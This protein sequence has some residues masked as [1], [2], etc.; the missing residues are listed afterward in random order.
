MNGKNLKPITIKSPANAP[1]LKIDRGQIRLNKVCFAYNK[2]YVLKNIN[3]E[4]KSGEKIALV[5]PSGAG[6]STF[7]KLLFRF[8]DP[9][10]GQKYRRSHYYFIEALKRILDTAKPMLKKKRLLKPLN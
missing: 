5:G 1:S 9:S 2:R 3:L 10:N 4:I 7:I 8:I 6:K